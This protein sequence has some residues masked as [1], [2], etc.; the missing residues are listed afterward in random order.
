MTGRFTAILH[1]KY[2][3]RRK[4][5]VSIFNKKISL[6]SFMDYFSSEEECLELYFTLKFEGCKCHK[7]GRSVVENYTRILRVDANGVPK[8]AFRCR[9]CRTYIYP[10]SY[11]VFRR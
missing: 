7:C 2:G 3:F 10:L 8:K 5:H 9:S 11:T 4:N 1:L 6:Y